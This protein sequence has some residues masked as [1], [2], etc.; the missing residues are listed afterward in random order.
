M[1]KIS[2]LIIFPIIFSFVNLEP[3]SSCEC[4]TSHD[5]PQEIE[6]DSNFVASDVVIDN[7]NYGKP[8][9]IGNLVFLTKYVDVSSGTTSLEYS[10]PTGFRLPT[11]SEF[12][13]MLSTLGSQANSILSNTS[14]FNFQSDSIYMT[15]DK[16]Y[17]SNTNGETNEAWMFYGLAK[18]G[19]SYTIKS[20]NSYWDGDS[21]VARCMM[22][23]SNMEFNIDGLTYDLLTNEKRTLTLDKSMLK[24]FL[25]RFDNELVSGNTLE[26]TNTKRG[27]N[28]LEIWATTLNDQEVYECKIIYTRPNLGN[29]VD[30]SFSMSK[31]STLSNKYYSERVS[32]MHF[33]R[34]QAPIAPKYDGGYY[35]S[36]NKK[37][38]HKLC[39]VEF[40]SNDKVINEKELGYY[41]YPLDIIETDYG[42]AVYARDYNDNHHSF[43][44][45][46][47]S[48][49]TKRKE[50]TIMNN[51]DKPSSTVDALV[52]YDSSGSLLFGVDTMYEP[53]N[54]KLAYGK[55]KLNLIFAHYNIFDGE[56]H[57]GDTYYSLDLSGEPETAKYAWTWQTSHSL[58]Q[59]H[60]YDGKYFITAALGDA[61]PQGI[62]L[63]VIDINKGGNVYDSKRAS[64][65]DLGLVTSSDVI[66][67][68]VGDGL[69][70]S[71]GRLAGVLEFNNVYA[72]IY[73]VKKSSDDER[74]GIFLT[75]FNYEDGK[76]NLLSTNYILYGIAGKLKNLRCAKY[77][78]RVL[79][80]YILNKTD[81][82]LDYPS[83]YTDLNEDTFYLVS[84]LDG[85]VT[86]G[87]FKSSAQ[88]Q[89]ISED[90]RELKDGSLRWGYVDSND[91]LRIV[92]VAAPT[93]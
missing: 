66:G 11:K 63:S 1:S 39:I 57:T 84:D 69:G 73:S 18:S 38:N 89:A 40:D 56:G 12:E 53:H 93:A 43:V 44:V 2:I 10:C 45:T 76:I 52:F 74:D 3:S 60:I 83:G 13:T 61:Y 77:G 71:Y 86:A 90:I 25:W 15:N 80:T 72:V 87:P 50:T 6:I 36:Y 23:M 16:V 75:T 24:G 88:N 70:G 37:T 48:D 68:I 4:P 58:V 7:V 28:T 26:I 5:I 19:S 46:Y 78:G 17:P 65:P 79:I 54:G 59:S 41:A 47:N 21:M 34:P 14:G 20:I 51:G 81:Y 32:G 35:M 31:V 33:E 9:S 8:I 49:Y 62:S 92:K 82:E 29:S 64:Y 91:V 67:N 42:F 27:C 85:N 30:S 55:G 22:D